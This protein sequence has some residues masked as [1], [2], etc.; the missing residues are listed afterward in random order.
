MIE[1]F[2]LFVNTCTECFL[3]SLLRVVKL[4]Y[5]KIKLLCEKKNV[6]I[7]RL[8]KDLELST[9]SVSKWGV[10]MPRADTLVK[11][12]NYLGVSVEELIG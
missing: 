8:E 5:Q 10:S 12:A 4:V 6:S 3:N 2:Q 7:Y 11:V 9:G 1:Y